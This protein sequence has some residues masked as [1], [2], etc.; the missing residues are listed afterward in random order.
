[1]RAQGCVAL[2]E[3]THWGPHPVSIFG[4]CV[5]M[6]LGLTLRRIDS[7]ALIDLREGRARPCVLVQ[8]KRA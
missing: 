5:I 2:N 8:S 6:G 4:V 3:S 7:L 1:M